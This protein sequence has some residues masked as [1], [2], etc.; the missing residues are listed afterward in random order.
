[1]LDEPMEP[2]SKRGMHRLRSMGMIWCGVTPVAGQEYSVTRESL[3][4]TAT[5]QQL[6]VVSSSTRLR[7]GPR[8]SKGACSGHT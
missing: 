2:H 4:S 7:R 3:P 1:M 8:C 5:R 6:E